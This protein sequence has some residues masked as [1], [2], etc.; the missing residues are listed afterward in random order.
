M[1]LKELEYFVACAE[2]GSCGK[3]AERLFTSQANVSKTIRRLEEDLGYPLFH[4]RSTGI[5]LTTDGDTLYG[6]AKSILEKAA[7][8]ESRRRVSVQEGLAIAS[9]PSNF[10][11]GRFVNFS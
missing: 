5:V 6:E 9:N 2:A 7:R 8:I 10:L 1:E 3:A 11:A 4:R